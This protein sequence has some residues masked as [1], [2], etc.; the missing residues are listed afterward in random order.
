M[1][2]DQPIVIVVSSSGDVSGSDQETER[3]RML[4]ENFETGGHFRAMLS[5]GIYL[6]NV[7]QR[8]GKQ[9]TTL[10]SYGRGASQVLYKSEIGDGGSSMQF[11]VSSG[12]YVSDPHS[13]EKYQKYIWI[14]VFCLS[15]GSLLWAGLS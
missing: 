4:L 14:L 2:D 11:Q 6:F 15:V 3:G 5:A 12:S 7:V 1:R 8:D 10:E 13:W 9:I